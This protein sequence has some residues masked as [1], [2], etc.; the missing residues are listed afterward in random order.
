[1]LVI[2]I[3]LFNIIWDMKELINVINSFQKLDHETEDA[4]KEYF[5]EEKF[6]KMN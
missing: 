2:F 3:N 4:I 5:V 6:K 1:M